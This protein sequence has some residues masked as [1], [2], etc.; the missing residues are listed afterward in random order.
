VSSYRVF[1]VLCLFSLNLTRYC[2]VWTVGDNWPQGGEIDIIEGVNMGNTNQMT[3]MPH[4]HNYMM[5]HFDKSEREYKL[6]C[7]FVFSLTVHSV[8]G[9]KVKDQMSQSATGK[10]LHTDCDAT[11]TGELRKQTMDLKEKECT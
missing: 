2:L 8:P 10:V 5:V 6:D 4:N 9:C 3:R 1:F 7:Q 11:G